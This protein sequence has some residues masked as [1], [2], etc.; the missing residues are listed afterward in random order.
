MLTI[1]ATI[2]V[3]CFFQAL[4]GDFMMFTI[5]TEFYATVNNTCDYIM[6][7]EAYFTYPT[8]FAVPKGSPFENVLNKG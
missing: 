4:E 7:P 5:E 8:G 3:F 2:T 1:K 6:L